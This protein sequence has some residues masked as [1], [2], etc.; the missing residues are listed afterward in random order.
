[1]NDLITKSATIPLLNN[2]AELFETPV[3]SPLRQKAVMFCPLPSQVRH[4][5]WWLQHNFSQV[6]LGRILSD[7]SPVNRTELMNKFQNMAPCAV[8][9][10]TMKLGGTGLNLMAANHAIILQKPWVLNE[11]RRAFGQIVRLGQTCQ[12]HCWLL[13]VGP[14]GYED[15]VTQL[16][17]QS[18]QVQ[19]R[20]LHG[21]KN[22]LD[23]ST[24]DIY[25]MLQIRQEETRR[26]ESGSV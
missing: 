7:N 11:Q 25:N 22:R 17:H 24:Q 8:F 9:L 10:T 12:L 1:M 26:V 3:P 6:L 19:M 16:H 5:Q 13:N 18:G 20:I 4:V 2:R 15:R 14:G 21:V 23:I